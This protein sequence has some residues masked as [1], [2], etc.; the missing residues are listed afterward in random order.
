[1]GVDIL[2]PVASTPLPTKSGRL[3]RTVKCVP[4]ARAPFLTLLCARRSNASYT[5]NAGRE[6]EKQRAADAALA[7]QCGAYSS[8]PVACAALGAG[9]DDAKNLL[10]KWRKERTLDAHISAYKER[11]LPEAPMV[12]AA[13]RKQVLSDAVKQMKAGLSLRRA[14]TVCA[15]QGV[16]IQKSALHK[17][18]TGETVRDTVGAPNKL[19][20]DL[21]KELVEYVEAVKVAYMLSRVFIY[22]VSCVYI[23][24]LVCVCMLSRVFI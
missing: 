19:P 3:A 22:A 12:V 18:K 8:L 24:C 7:A 11:R 16:Q 20:P 4:S 21:L 1:M 6:V 13:E 17:R 14:V 9:L 15:A 2:S 10:K 5:A 23:C